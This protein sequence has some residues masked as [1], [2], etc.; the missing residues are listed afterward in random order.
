[1]PI[2]P[3]SVAPV[4]RQDI[5]RV[6]DHRQTTSAAAIL[7]AAR[8]HGPVA[9]S[10]VAR[11]AGLSGPAVSRLSADLVGA[12]LL[13]DAP[14]TAGRL[15]VGR[16]H[17]PVDIDT[18]CLVACGL[19][20][21][22]ESATLALLDLRGRVVAREQLTHASLRPEA[23]LGRLAGRIP[24]FIAEHAGG[25]SP[26]GLGVATGGWVDPADGR[27]VEHPVLGWRDVRARDILATATGLPVRLDNHSRSL[28]RAE[29]MFGDI[30]ARASVVYLVVGNVVDAAFATG[31]TVHQG[32]QSA[33]GRIAHLPLDGR[34]ERC[35][36]GRRGCLQAVV[37]S[38]VMARRA[39][40]D[41][42]TSRPSFAA[43]L[44]AA[45]A[46][47]RRALVMFRD[48]ARMIGAAAALL[49]EVL[50]PELLVIAEAGV[51][52]LPDCLEL[53]RSEVAARSAMAADGGRPVVATSFAADAAAI[54]GGAGILA[55]VYANPLR[56][57]LPNASSCSPWR[58]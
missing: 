45:S 54:A 5:R 30:R 42:I 50:N 17:V 51:A 35:S 57:L 24:A 11:L 55:E 58:S 38:Q 3:A 53:L 33:A 8:D 2:S 44:G 16:P 21:A 27:I 56:S 34:S 48:R 39:A 40:A 9:R 31:A 19:H 7:Q 43:L 36:C 26:L 52:Q 13:R 15:G 12:G 25:R 23:V 14:E 37:S 10:S 4:R 1:V 49:L 6:A 18:S 28:A 20:I 47:H 41:G 46:G 29:R 32:P 22:A